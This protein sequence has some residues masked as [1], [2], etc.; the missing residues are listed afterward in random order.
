MDMRHKDSH[1][2]AFSLLYAK[3]F[4][5]LCVTFRKKVHQKDRMSRKD[6]A[7]IIQRV[8]GGETQAFAELNHGT[9]L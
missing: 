5:L 3:K 2:S 8:L 1:F 4:L 6:D 9:V 7:K